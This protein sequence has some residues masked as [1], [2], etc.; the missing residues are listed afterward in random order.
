MI[1]SK[2]PLLAAG[3]SI[4]AINAVLPSSANAANDPGLFQG[5]QNAPDGEN[6]YTVPATNFYGGIADVNGDGSVLVTCG[7]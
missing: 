4:L 3:V 2:L 6:L 1:R 7:Q 5:D